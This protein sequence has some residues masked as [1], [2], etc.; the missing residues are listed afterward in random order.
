MPGLG[1]DRRLCAVNVLLPGAGLLIAG[2]MVSGLFLL[3]PT[4]LLLALMLGVLGLFSS[5]AA[6]G[7]LVWLALPY[8]VLAAFAGAWW[9]ACTRREHYDPAEVRRVHREAAAAYLQ[10]QQAAALAGATRLTRLAPEEAGTWHFL[11]L[12]ASDAGNAALARKA[13]ARAAAIDDR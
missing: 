10:G 7:I 4:I 1:S 8:G 12:I 3:L 9:W 5:E 6:W 11:A 2:R 13:A